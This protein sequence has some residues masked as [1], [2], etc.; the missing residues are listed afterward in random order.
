MSIADMRRQYSMGRL[1]EEALTQ[2]PIDL[3][4]Q[5]LGE[6]IDAKIPDPTAMTVATVDA[7]GQPSQ[8]IVLLKDYD[9]DGF[10]FYTNLGSRKAKELAENPKIS[11]HF[12]WFFMERQ[13]RVCGVAEKLSVAQNAKYF[14]SRP[15]DSQLAAWA[16]QQSQPIS[17]RELLMTQ[18]KQMKDKFANKDIPLPDFWGGFKVKPSQIEFWQGGE[19]RLHDRFEYRFDAEAGWSTQRLM[20]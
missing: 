11:L 8:R 19:D 14:L 9:H 10:V 4:K 16:S 13:V 18:F 5:W 7:S 12:P 2:H 20:P 17:S 1:T 6:A 15:K 3:F